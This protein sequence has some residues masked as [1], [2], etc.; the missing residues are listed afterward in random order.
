MGP[1]LVLIKGKPTNASVQQL[2]YMFKVPISNKQWLG[3][4]GKCVC[5]F[6]WLVCPNVGVELFELIQHVG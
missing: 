4:A 1:L 3:G 6:A 2:L 5:V